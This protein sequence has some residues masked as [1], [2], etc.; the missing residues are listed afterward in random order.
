VLFRSEDTPYQ[1]VALGY[2]HP[3]FRA[4]FLRARKIRYDEKL[5]QGED[6][7]F[8]AE[9]LLAGAQA[10]AVPYAGY[11]YSFR[12]LFVSEKDK[13]DLGASK[14]GDVLKANDYLVSRYGYSMPPQAKRALLYR[15]SLFQELAYARRIRQSFGAQKKGEAVRLLIKR[16]SVWPFLV[17][18]SAL[19]F[20]K[21]RAKTD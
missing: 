12:P 8:L 14:Y 20:V 3:L 13:S 15:R 11:I 21:P 6:F 5:R 9:C 10:F 4:S 17:K 19:G 1:R 16:P 18:M 7:L 2:A